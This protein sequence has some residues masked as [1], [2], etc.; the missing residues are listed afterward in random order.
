V[1]VERFGLEGQVYCVQTMRRQ[2][3]ISLHL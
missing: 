2:V 3:F 1:L